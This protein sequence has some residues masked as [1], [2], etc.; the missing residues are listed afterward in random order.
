M[1]LKLENAIFQFLPKRIFVIFKIVYS[2][3][4]I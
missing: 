1:T 3:H 2:K 4:V